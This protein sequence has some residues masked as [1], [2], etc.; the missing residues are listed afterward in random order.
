MIDQ[1]NKVLNT[2]GW[3]SSLQDDGK[4]A[5]YNSKNTLLG[6]VKAVRRRYQYR[7][8]NGWLIASTNTPERLAFLITEFYYCNVIV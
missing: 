8:I 2:Y 1:L 6:Y 7:N 4:I 5:I 3:R